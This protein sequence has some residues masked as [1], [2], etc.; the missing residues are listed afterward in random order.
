MNS[1][2]R[3]QLAILLE[4]RDL[5]AYRAVSKIKLVLDFWEAQDFE[6]AE[7]ILRSALAEFDEADRNVN[8]LYEQLKP[9]TEKRPANGITTAS[10]HSDSAAG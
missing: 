4:R 7:I 1:D 5:A 2:P 9:K 6:N 8:T 10:Q 3:T